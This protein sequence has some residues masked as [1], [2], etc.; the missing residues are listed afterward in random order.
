MTDITHDIAI[1]AKPDTLYQALTSAQG[2]KSWFTLQVSGSGKVGTIWELSFTDQPSFKWEIIAADPQYIAWKCIQ[3]PGNAAGT[4][5]EF[6]LT[7]KTDNQTILT[8][9]HRG[10]EANDPKLAKCIEIWRTLMNH[11]QQYCEMG[12]PEPAYH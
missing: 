10:W 4:Q 12:K 7:P 6:K 11:L 5:V 8:I 9:S 2:L 3:G 1:N